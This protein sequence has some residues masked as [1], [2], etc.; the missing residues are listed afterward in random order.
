MKRQSRGGLDDDALEA[1][2]RRASETEAGGERMAAVAALK[3]MRMRQRAAHVLCNYVRAGAH[4]A[5]RA[6]AAGVLGYHKAASVFLELQEGL[7]AHGQQE[8]DRVVAKTIA[9]ALRGTP[10][11]LA[12]LDHGQ[13]GVVAEA[14]L[15]APLSEAG[16]TALLGRVFEGVDGEVEALILRRVQAER[17]AARQVAPFLM[18]ADFP[19]ARGDPTPRV[20]R[21]F[22]VLPQADLFAALT[23]AEE[24]IQRTYKEIWPGIRRRERTRALMKIFEDR[25]RNDGASEA[26]IEAL[27]ERI[28]VDDGFYARYL[29]FVRS[30]LRTLDAEG[31]DVVVDRVVRIADEVNREEI[32]RLA[33]FLVTLTRAM[34]A[35]GQRVLEVLGRWEAVLPGVQVKAFHARL[36]TG[37]FRNSSDLQKKESRT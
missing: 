9:F 4:P 5:W 34:P 37:F 1:L 18:R 3:A 16:W 23:G 7:L 31:T 17:G 22:G 28:V 36:G 30:L 12:L 32:A 11:V 8:R 2:V 15:G 35:A 26:L 29:R 19:E 20:F 6:T 33:E 14:V 13:A 21:L 10:R 25:V 27:I 24:E